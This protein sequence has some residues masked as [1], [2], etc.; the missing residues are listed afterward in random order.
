[1]IIVT[2]KNDF[3]I[4]IIYDWSSFCSTSDQE[5]REKEDK[6][7]GQRQQENGRGKKNPNQNNNIMWWM[8][9]N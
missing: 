5:A 7:E 1:M 3:V 4:V 6:E 8:E 9:L 2:A